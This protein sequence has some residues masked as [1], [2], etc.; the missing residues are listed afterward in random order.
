MEDGKGEGSTLPSKSRDCVPFTLMLPAFIHSVKNEEP[1]VVLFDS[2]SSHTWVSHRRLPKGI[3]GRTNKSVTS[4]TLA[5]PLK[6]SQEVDLHGIVFPEFF[7]TRS[8]EK[9]TTR[10]FHT[11]C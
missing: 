5:G 9:L 6:G 2:G 1:L 7:K 11:E 10:V 8:I 3:Q 4:Q